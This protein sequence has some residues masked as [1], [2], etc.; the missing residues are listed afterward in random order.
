MSI[1]VSRLGKIMVVMGSIAWTAPATAAPIEVLVETVQ[2]QEI[3]D[4][5]EALG[6]LRA[7][8]AVDVTVNVAE[9]V[10]S[11]GFQSGQRVEKGQVLLTL[12]SGEERALVEEAKSTRDEA[13][14]QLNRIRALAKRG[15]ASQSLLDETQRE[16]RVSEA[17]LAAVESRLQYR[18]IK[19]PFSGLVGLRNISPGA[20]LAP[21]DTV[22]TLVDDRSMK[23]DFNVPSLFLS[24]LRPGV[25][26]VARSRALANR[27]FNGEVS[28]VDNRV[29]PIS[30]SITVRAELDNSDSVLR[31][32]MLMEVTLESNPRQMPVISESALIQLQDRSYVYVVDQ[33]DGI[34]FA[35][36]LPVTTGLRLPGKIEIREGLEAGQ[37]I[38]VEGAVKLT[39]DSPVKVLE[40]APYGAR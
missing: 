25:P 37:I 24:T 17:R 9:T 13:R 29:D 31:A 7:N 10:E 1:E 5:L 2:T 39:N 16:F 4:P 32:G 27:R 12:E 40:N 30:R 3:S 11:I 34:T 19:A 6:T 14:A 26:I 22:T 8:E 15:D 36:R 23:L 20:Y 33:E 21:G 18:I 28:S 38:V 35:R